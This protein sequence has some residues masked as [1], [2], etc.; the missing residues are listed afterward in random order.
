MTKRYFEYN[1]VVIEAKIYGTVKAFE[2]DNPHLTLIKE[3]D[4]TEVQ[5]EKLI[6]E[7]KRKKREK[8]RK[9]ILEIADRDKQ[10]QMIFDCLEEMETEGIAISSE[11]SSFIDERNAIK[12]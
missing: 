7:G 9:Q 10:L 6:E 3:T 4:L 12:D 8:K 1:G 2:A 5:K 11:V